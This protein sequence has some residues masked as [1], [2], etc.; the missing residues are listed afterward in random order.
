MAPTGTETPEGTRPPGE[1]RPRFGR[2]AKRLLPVLSIFVFLGGA[3]L[4]LWI[5]RSAP[6]PNPPFAFYIRQ[7]ENDVAYP[8]MQEDPYLLWSP[9]PGAETRMT[10]RDA[11]RTVTITINAVGLRDEPYPAEK[12]PGTFRIL[13]LGDSSTFGYQVNL[14]ETY[15]AVLEAALAA[16]PDLAPW[17][18][19]V[20]SAG[21]T[22]YTSTQMLEYYRLRGRALRSDL[23]TVMAGA[24][25]LLR[26]FRWPDSELLRRS[27]PNGTKKVDERL[28]Q[29]G[30]YRTLR[31]WMRQGLGLQTPP[32]APLSMRCPPA[33]YERNLLELSRLCDADGARLVL[34]SLP[35]IGS[36]G[37]GQDDIYDEQ[38]ALYHTI[39]RTLRR[40]HA[41][42]L[43]EVPEMTRGWGK[44]DVALF[45]DRF[46]PTPRGHRL[47]G[48]RLSAWLKT[49]YY[50]PRRPPYGADPGG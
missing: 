3:E 47:L 19:E 38:V 23:V 30:S 40:E 36:R 24:N 42:P 2:G 17:R 6:P 5:T 44:V 15:H 18:F 50:V 28:S 16:D 10:D 22:G 43:F 7:G 11:G 33:E 9:R 45:L 26:K 25:D 34:L 32:R 48:L 8:F 31:G 37:G 29:L 49:H 20:I 12:A 46:H 27:R 39:L 21:V 35:Y 14:G 4:A 1:R 41:L 13:C